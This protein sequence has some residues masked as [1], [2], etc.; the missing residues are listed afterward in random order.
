MQSPQASPYIRILQIDVLRGFALLGIYWMNVSVF[1][2]PSAIFGIPNQLGEMPMLNTAFWAFSKV[3]VEGS[4][5]GLFSVLFGGSALI[6]LDEARQIASGTELIDRFY[7]RNMIL[8]LFGVLHA[9]F[10]VWPYDVLYSYGLIGMFLFPLRKISP[11]KL[12]IASAVLF[13]LAEINFQELAGRI[14]PEEQAVKSQQKYTERIENMNVYDSL[15]YQQKEETKL[16]QSGYLKIF[17][18][19]FSEVAADQ[20][21]KMY[22]DHF[23]D[24]G[25][26]MLLGMAL[27][28]LG[29]LSGNSSL[30]FYFLL[31]IFGYATGITYRGYYAWEAITNNLRPEFYLGNYDSN[32][33]LGRLPITLGH[34]GLIGILCKLK[35]LNWITDLLS[36]IGRMALTNYIMQTL[37]S[38]FIFYGFGLGLYGKLEHYELVYFILGMWIFQLSFSRIW[39]QYFRQGPLE[40]IWRSLIYG[41]TEKFRKG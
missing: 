38:I 36:Y 21:T 15:M 29:I 34:V 41:R 1:A 17:S 23:Y 37:I 32:Y 13:I 6:F 14:Y 25:G 5:R 24:I 9:F 8:I 28:K 39:L 19:K 40:W 22:N 30:L 31:M 35:F 16:F 27:M 26:M 4:M 20:S 11:K 18:K 33:T 2:I 7:R 10:L 3:F 12:L